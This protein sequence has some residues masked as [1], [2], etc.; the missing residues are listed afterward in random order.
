MTR[1]TPRDVPRVPGGDRAHGPRAADLD[2]TS[3]LAID[4]RVT[5][6]ALRMGCMKRLQNLSD[7]TYHRSGR[8]DVPAAHSDRIKPAIL[9][10]ISHP[11]GE[12]GR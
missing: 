6:S 2:H 3:P 12:Q 7:K 1:A 10:R 11:V 9:A 5:V 8:Q 4:D